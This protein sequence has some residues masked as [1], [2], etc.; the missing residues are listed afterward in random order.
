MV[1]VNDITSFQLDKLLCAL[2]LAS[3]YDEYAFMLLVFVTRTDLFCF[4]I[5]FR[6]FIIFY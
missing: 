6:E 4:T 2:L 5:V 1:L 3:K